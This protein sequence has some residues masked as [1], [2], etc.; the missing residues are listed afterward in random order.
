MSK[1][2]YCDNTHLSLQDRMTIQLGIENNSTKVAIAKNLGKDPS[3]IAKEIK[4]HRIFKRRNRFNSS[5][6]CTL[7]ARCKK[8]TK[9]KKCEN[10]QAPRCSR[11]DK[12]PGACNKCP[13]MSSCRM[14][15][16]LYDANIAHEYYRKTLVDTRVGINM[17]PSEFQA[18]AELISPLINQGQSIYQVLLAHP[19]IKIS[20]R[21]IYN[22]IDQGLLKPYGVDHFSLKEKTQRK[23]PKTKYKKRND[24][25]Y[26]EHRR[27]V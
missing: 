5:T 2:H 7:I 13:K 6:D 20:E 9:G 8:C 16:F 1:R 22:Y 23:L 25:S 4:K 11:R 15:K 27:S 18:L 14:M 19:E 10:Y 24:R 21:T 12:S 17:E 26:L 3:T